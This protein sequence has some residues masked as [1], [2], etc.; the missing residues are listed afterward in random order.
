MIDRLGSLLRGTYPRYIAASVVALAIDWGLYVLLLTVATPALA[1]AGGYSLGILVHWLISSRLVF[2]DQTAVER[3][4][5][6]RQK[7]LFIASALAGL[8][9]TVGIVGVGDTAG[10]D[11]LLAKAIATVISF[12]TTYVL[13]KRI[14]FRP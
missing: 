4:L 7:G 10:L 13:R 5:R 8:A 9:I 14:V 1:A 2:A 11:P 6:N 3:A 12:Q